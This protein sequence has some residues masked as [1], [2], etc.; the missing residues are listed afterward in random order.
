LTFEEPGDS[1]GQIN[2]KSASVR[3]NASSCEFW[4]CSVVY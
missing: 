2:E 3:K 4:A 1:D